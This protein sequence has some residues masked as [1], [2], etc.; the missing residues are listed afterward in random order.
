MIEDKDKFEQAEFEIVDMEVDGMNRAQVEEKLEEL[1]KDLPPREGGVAK[2]GVPVGEVGVINRDAVTPTDARAKISELGRRT[3][4][5]LILTKDPNEVD[6]FIEMQGA[7]DSAIACV[8]MAAKAE[9]KFV[10]LF[11]P[12]QLNAKFKGVPGHGRIAVQSFE[13]CRMLYDMGVLSRI[14]VC[15]NLFKQYPGQ[16][17]RSDHKNAIYEYDIDELQSYIFL[18]GKAILGVPGHEDPN[19]VHWIYVEGKDNIYDPYPIV[20]DRYKTLNGVMI[21]EAVIVGGVPN[22]AK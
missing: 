1:N 15:L 22:G 17:W 14:V 2:I 5:K 21:A 12:R 13:M 19:M 20:A 9:Y 3:N 10:S 6:W 8:A 16:E 11:I 18:G 4:P 7:A